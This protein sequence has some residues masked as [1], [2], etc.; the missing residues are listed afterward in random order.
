[1]AKIIFIDDNGK[2]EILREGLYVK[3]DILF[4]PDYFATKLWC[5]EDVAMALSEKGIEPSQANVSA[6]IN[7]GMLKYL[8]DCT[9]ADWEAINQAIGACEQDGL[10]VTKPVK[11]DELCGLHEH[12]VKMCIDGDYCERSFIV[13]GDDNSEDTRKDL[14]AAL[15]NTLHRLLDN[16]ATEDDIRRELGAV[17]YTDDMD[18]DYIIHIDLGYVLPGPI[19]SVN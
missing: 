6:I 12:V 10:L 19:L 2:E 4:R 3:G 8:G 14:S 17:Q 11:V 1:M 18:D 9:D 5:D 16:G 7:T 15:E 13:D